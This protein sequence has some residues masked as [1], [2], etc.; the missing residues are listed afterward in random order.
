[1][2]LCHDFCSSLSSLSPH[3]AWLL[4]DYQSENMSEKMILKGKT[5]NKEDV[6]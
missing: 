4:A 6:G 1:M 2:L 3:P 5:G